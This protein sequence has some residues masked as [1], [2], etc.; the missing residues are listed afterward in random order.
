MS[1]EDAVCVSVRAC[2]YTVCVHVVCACVFHSDIS[3][4][5][6]YS[7]TLHLTPLSVL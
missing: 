3:N 1:L 6:F 4:T 2:V 5:K 7:G